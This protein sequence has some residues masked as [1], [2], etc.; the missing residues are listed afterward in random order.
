MRHGTYDLEAVDALNIL[1]YC[2]DPDCQGMN[3]IG[4]ANALDWGFLAESHYREK[5]TV[6][7]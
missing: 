4:V 6:G 7:G 2:A 5:V 1:V 3:P